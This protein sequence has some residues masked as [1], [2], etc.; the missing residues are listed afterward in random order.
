MKPNYKESAKIYRKLYYDTYNQV[1]ELQMVQREITAHL[2]EQKIELNEL[3]IKYSEAI[4]FKN[5]SSSSNTFISFSYA[6]L[7]IA[8]FPRAIFKALIIV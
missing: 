8:S 2:T 5:S 4:F 6:F 1:G 3:K 7:D